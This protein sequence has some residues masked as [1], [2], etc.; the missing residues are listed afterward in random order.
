MIDC[1]IFDLDGVVVDTARYHYLAWAALARELGFEFTPVQGEATKGVSRMASLEIVLR[2]GGLEGRFSAAERE[3]L[4]AEK[5]ARY[6]RFV[7]QMT[8][9][10]VLPGVAAF[11]HDVRSRG[12]P[13]G[14]RFGV[15]E[16]GDDPRPVRPSAAVDAVVD[17]NEFR[18]QTRSRGFPKGA[19]AV[20]AAPSVCVVFEDA[21]AGI[22]AASRAGMRSVGVGGVRRFRPPRCGWKPFAGFTF[23]Q[24]A[25]KH[26]P[27]LIATPAQRRER[28]RPGR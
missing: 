20:D 27:G 21:A 18:G 17:G 10:E 7:S 15:E 9:A 2:A 28:L 5:N 25:M 8:P 4:A 14:A 23:E 13:D 22:E 3:R 19:A 24:L 11:L 16:R 26:R 1:C 12:V 6:L